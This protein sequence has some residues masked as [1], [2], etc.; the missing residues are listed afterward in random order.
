MLAAC[1][2]LGGIFAG[3]MILAALLPWQ[4]A[5]GTVLS[6][7]TYSAVGQFSEH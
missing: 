4:V 3:T 2:D 1:Y 7:E 6:C 5:V